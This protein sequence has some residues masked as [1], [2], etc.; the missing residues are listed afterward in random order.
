MS[1]KYVIETTSSGKQKFVK[2]KRSRSHG[3]SHDHHHHLFDHHHH[4]RHCHDEEPRRDYYKVSVEEWNILKERERILDEQNRALADENKSLRD[5]LSAAQAEVH[6]LEHC[7]IP[8]LQA[9]NNILYADNQSLRRSID[10]AA[11]QAAKHHADMDKLQCKADKL[12][13]ENKEV[14]DENCDLRQRIR[15]LS[16]Q[17][18][19]SY[20]RRVADLAHE[21]AHFKEEAQYWKARFENVKCRLCEAL[22]T[23]DIRTERMRAYEEILK[24]RGI[25]VG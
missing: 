9:Q 16:K 8:D 22:D 13:K 7:V 17:L 23:L 20:N 4:H 15:A 2:L 18:D 19:Q 12:E 3:H 5:N 11:E 25:M 1:P 6:R 21:L 24:R 14:K 10:N